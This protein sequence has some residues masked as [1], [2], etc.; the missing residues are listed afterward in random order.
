MS[1]VKF[2]LNYQGVG[3][4]LHSSEMVSVLQSRAQ[5]VANN[6]GE[7]FE[8]KQMPTRAI[9]V[10]TASRKATKDNLEN[11]TLLKAVR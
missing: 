1:K 3:A 11:N 2:K 4:L 6:A 8:V 5:S 10:E 7:G 9:V